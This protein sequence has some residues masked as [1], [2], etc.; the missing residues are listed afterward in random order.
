MEKPHSNR[1][2][3]FKKVLALV[4]SGARSNERTT[5]T[6]PEFN[7]LYRFY[8]QLEADRVQVAQANEEHQGENTLNTRPACTSLSPTS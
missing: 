3:T 4:R 1:P 5:G 6:L 2:L 8:S 7:R